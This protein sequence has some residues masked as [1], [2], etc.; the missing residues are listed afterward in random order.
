M[1]SSPLDICYD[2]PPVQ[3][4]QLTQ[5]CKANPCYCCI[6]AAVGVLVCV[7]G[8]GWAAELLLQEELRQARRGVHLQEGTLLKVHI[9]V[10]RIIWNNPKGGNFGK[11][12]K[13]N[14]SKN[15]FA[16]VG[17]A[18][19]DLEINNRLGGPNNRLGEPNNRGDGV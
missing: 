3:Y 19:N 11:K 7:G 4:T 1:L 16:P 15:F 18:W 8:W 17:E 2:F 9:E 13:L 14:K 10:G 12:S 6:V 5:I